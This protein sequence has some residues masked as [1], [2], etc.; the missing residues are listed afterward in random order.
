MED[1]VCD[2]FVEN[3]LKQS[4]YCRDFTSKNKITGIDRNG[5]TIK[6]QVTP[7]F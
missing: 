2:C 5:E 4:F 7:F 3:L 1:E 6:E